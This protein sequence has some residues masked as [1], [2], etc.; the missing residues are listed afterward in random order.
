MRVPNQGFPGVH[1]PQPT[2]SKVLYEIRITRHE[3]RPLCS[4]RITSH[5]TRIKAFVFFTNH[6]TR[7]MVSMVHVGTEALQSFFSR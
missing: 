4:S 7:N 5:E 3:S 2:D 1:Q 6:G